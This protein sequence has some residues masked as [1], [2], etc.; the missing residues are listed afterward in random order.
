MQKITF[1]PAYVAFYPMLAEIAREKGYSL[2]IHG[3]VGKHGYSDLDLVAIPWVDDAKSKRELMDA[4]WDYAVQ[5]MPGYFLSFEKE[6]IPYAKPHGRE[7]WKLQLGNGASIDISVMPRL[8][9]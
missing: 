1:A 4:I 6:W 3:S 7:A 2:A 9:P 5:I 8:S